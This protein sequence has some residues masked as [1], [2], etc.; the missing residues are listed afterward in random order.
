M[1]TL[2]LILLLSTSCYSQVLYDWT[3]GVN[4]GWISSNTSNNTLSWQNS[5]TTVSSSGFNT[6][7]GNWYTYNNNQVT[8]YTSPVYNFTSCSS[9]IQINI[10]MDINLENRY[11]WLYFQYSSNGGTTWTN[12]TTPVIATNNSGV[13]LSAYPPQ[14]AWINN[15]SN[16]NGWSGALGTITV[17][18][19]LPNLANRFRFIFATDPSV[20]TYGPG[21]NTYIYYVDILDFT[22]S[23]IIPLPVTI[24]SFKGENIDNYNKLY[25]SVEDEINCDYYK[26]ESSIDGYN[27]KLVDSIKAS[28]SSNYTIID[29]NP[30]NNINY[31]KLTEVDLDGI[32]NIYNKYTVIDNSINDEI[33]SI[34]NLL[35]QSINDDYKGL[36]LIT[37]R[38]GKVKKIFR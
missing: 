3:N 37:Y 19:S 4:P 16:R 10:T 18:F 22:V 35:G 38:N 31:Y 27:W 33:V 36:V 26:V 15:T 14:T 6:G 2:L 1:K 5:I 8:T 7:T 23:C 9:N 32:I 24:T 12:P 25:W 11:D 21:I 30:N 29:K 28:N 34:T 20:N 13:N 17:N